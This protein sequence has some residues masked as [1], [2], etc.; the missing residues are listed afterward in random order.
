MSL[1]IKLSRKVRSAYTFL[2]VSADVPAGSAN[3]QVLFRRHAQML[4]FLTEDSRSV[5]QSP[6]QTDRE[7]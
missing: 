6:L 2:S 7:N 1:N 5:L 4:N 3:L